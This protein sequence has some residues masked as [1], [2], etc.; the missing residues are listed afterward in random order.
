M[1]EAQYKQIIAGLEEAGQGSPKG[2]TYH[3]TF[4]TGN[5]LA[6]F[7]VFDS[8][9]DFEALGAPLMPVVAKVGVDPGTWRRGDGDGMD[10]GVQVVDGGAVTTVYS[11][12]IDPK[13]NRKERHWFDESVDLT[14]WLG[15][16]IEIALIVTGGPAGDV[17]N[18]IA[19]WGDLRFGGRGSEPAGS[20]LQL[21]YR[22][23]DA[24]IYEDDSALP[25][26]FLVRTIDNVATPDQ[27]VEA[28]KDPDFDPQIRAVLEGVLPPQVAAL[29]RPSRQ[30]ATG[31]VTVLEHDA[32]RVRISVNSEG[33]G[34]LVLSDTYYP[35]WRAWVDGH[36]TDIF[37]ANLLFPMVVYLIV[38]RHLHPDVWLSPLMILGTQWYIL[39]NVIAGASAMPG[40][41]RHVAQNL[42]VRGW[43]WWRRIGL[44]AVLPFYV[45][46][47][48][49][50][51]GGSW[52]AAIVAELASWG[53]TQ[54][55]AHGIGAYIAEATIAGDFHH[56][57]LG[58]AVMS[59]FVLLVNR[60]FWR[61]LYFRAERR[62][63][64]T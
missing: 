5:H 29:D 58:I 42:G 15:R 26:A 52:N 19:L 38:T 23:A 3:C 61:P 25:R 60:L 36:E 16:D 50:A 51:S 34:V 8:Q 41:L 45:T 14:K 47:A 64:L 49:T 54:V 57:V 33:P 56:V 17:T 7:D 63:R 11:R 22:G 12:S 28:M 2:R 6:V 46:G 37:P 59:V 24:R 32:Q 4:G 55:Q 30:R 20:N 18:D 43:L 53:D 10:F 21:L 27:A 1:S 62:F 13:N 40:E 44:P 39:F 48:I 9:E 35:G 31:K